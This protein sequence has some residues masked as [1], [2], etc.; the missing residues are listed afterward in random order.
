MRF[1]YIASLAIAALVTVIAPQSRADEWNK[2]TVMTINQP[3]QLPN[4]MLQPGTYV[5]KLVDSPSDR[6]I[7][8]VFDKDKTHLI[9][10]ILAIPNYRL[11]PTGKSVFAF[12]ETPAGSPQAL[13]AWFYPGDNYGQEFAYPK[14]VS[15]KIAAA[16][17]AAVPTTTAQSADEMKTTPLSAVSADG[18]QDS[19]DAS[20]N[21]KP[22]D[23]AVAAAAPAP[24]P[25]P[26][27]V[28]EPPTQIAQATPPPATPVEQQTE[29]V[30]AEL[31]KTASQIPLTG[32]AGLM[33][34]AAFCALRRARRAH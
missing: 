8:Q 29:P 28:Q 18:Q 24:E 5:L 1:P 23:T 15:M 22:D 32:L 31:P 11:R 25:E 9:T 7:V 2:E 4:I 13:R 26:A 21:T 12:W 10:T 33:S 16:N 30:P 14:D 19:L 6:H 34:L 17:K 20:T 27:P 3:V